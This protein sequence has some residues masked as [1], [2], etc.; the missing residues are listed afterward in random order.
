MTNQL[1][2]SRTNAML[3]GVCEGLGRY[4]NIDTTLVRLIAVLLAL[5]DGIGVILY[6]MLW[7]IVP[8]EPVTG[9]PSSDT[10]RMG[11]DEVAQR[12]RTFG[13]ELG[14]AVTTAHPQ[15]GL[16][17]GAALIVLGALFL[18]QRLNL[19]WLDTDIVWPLLLIAGGAALLARR[20]RGE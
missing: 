7:I 3:G 12:M 10:A 9:V 11:A 13:G 16:F 5:T 19:L 4:L 14:N 15:A 18:L 1:Y 17:I 2:R 8:M 20:V 6:L